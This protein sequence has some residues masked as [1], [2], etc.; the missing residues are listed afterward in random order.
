MPKKKGIA[1]KLILTLRGIM[2]SQEVNWLQVT[3]MVPHG[4]IAAETTSVLM[5]KHLWTVSC[6]R[7]QASH[8]CGDL[9]PF[10]TIGQTFADFSNRW[11][12]TVFGKCTSM[13]HSPS[14]GKRLVHV[15]PIKVAITKNG[16]KWTLWI[17]TT[18][19][20]SKTFMS[21]TFP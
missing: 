21:S 13:V 3:S 4:G 19:G 2:I 16:F 9:D 6:L 11:V 12:L 15:P 1:K 5:T 8:Q 18:G 17:G 20:P 10:R 7:H 14:H